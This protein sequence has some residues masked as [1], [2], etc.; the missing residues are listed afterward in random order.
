MNQMYKSLCESVYTLYLLQSVRYSIVFH[1]LYMAP[2][3]QISIVIEIQDIL[4]THSLKFRLAHLCS[5]PKRVE[6][7]LGY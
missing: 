1:F 4:F 3:P 7:C 2:T 5:Y 6:K